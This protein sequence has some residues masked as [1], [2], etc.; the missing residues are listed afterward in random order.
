MQVE[1]RGVVDHCFPMNGKRKLIWNSTRRYPIHLEVRP[2]R[3][4]GGRRVKKL[5]VTEVRQVAPQR[6]GNLKDLQKL[7]VLR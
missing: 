7:V 1:Q 3:P 4:C 5:E 2:L 6:L